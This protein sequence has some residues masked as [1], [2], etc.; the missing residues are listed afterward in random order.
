[1][2][3]FL[4]QTV[5]KL[6][7]KINKA[8]CKLVKAVKERLVKEKIRYDDETPDYLQK[9]YVDNL[10]AKRDMFLNDERLI[11]IWEH[12]SNDVP[13]LND[14]YTLKGFC[15]VASYR[16]NN[17]VYK[18]LGEALTKLEKKKE[19]KQM[20]AGMVGMGLYIC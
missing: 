10:H 14:N 2:N 15:W 4:L 5:L 8:Q 11:H 20:T 9:L 3:I 7:D 12:F 13:D 6:Q 1:M 16:G 18:T 17:Y 19:K